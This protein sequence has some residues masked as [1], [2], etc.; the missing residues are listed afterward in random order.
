MRGIF[1]YD[2]RD[3]GIA[4]IAT[5]CRY[6]GLKIS[7]QYV[8]N[9][10][11]LDKNGLSMYGMISTFEKIGLQS[12]ALKGNYLELLDF[13]EEKK[14]PFIALVVD[15]FFLNHYII[16]K[17]IKKGKIFIFDPA[18]GNKIMKQK[19][20]EQI[21]TG[22]I[23]NVEK[24][25]S[26]SK[27]E[28]HKKNLQLYY[29]LVTSNGYKFAIVGIIS[30][31]LSILTLASAYIY[32]YIIDSYIMNTSLNSKEL[33]INTAQSNYIKYIFL[34]FMVI[35]L[36]RTIIS[37]VRGAIFA[38]VEK[39]IDN[40]IKSKFT[41]C[42]ISIPIRYY[43]DRDSGEIINR[44][45]NIVIITDTLVNILLSIV[46]EIVM[47]FS[48][49]II[50]FFTN[51][52]LFSVVAIVML[53]YTIIVLLFKSPLSKLNKQG[54][55]QETNII[56]QLKE[57]IDGLESIKGLCAEN[58]VIKTLQKKIS[59]NTENTYRIDI[60]T[61]FLSSIISCIESIALLFI[62]MWGST[63]VIS[64]AM[65]L[66][67]LIMF[68]S[69]IGFFITP[70]ESLIEYFPILQEAYIAFNRLDDVFEAETE[71]EEYPLNMEDFPEKQDIVLS[72]NNLF[73]HY[74]YEDDILSDVTFHIKSGEKIFLL[75]GSGS[76]KSTLAKLLVRFQDPSSGNIFA[77]NKNIKNINIEIL[78]KNIIYTSQN[79]FIFSGTVVENLMVGL[80][81]VSDEHFQEVLHFCGINDILIKRNWD[82]NS[83]ISEDGRNLSEG[84]KQRISIAR[85]LLR[86]GQIYIFDEATNHM[87]KSLEQKIIKYIYNKL[88]EKTCIFIMHNLD[89]LKE[90][91]RIFILNKGYVTEYGTYD[92]LITDSNNYSEIQS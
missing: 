30:V 74:G 48:S 29:Q 10:A 50:L 65:T 18:I 75:G 23:I 27:I 7:T 67:T 39:N 71:K 4:C 72:V 32:Q 89:Y 35:Y 63:M 8:R 51:R 59:L 1:Q 76:G 53:I 82:L 17:K 16:V 38:K 2:K 14:V 28:T 44:Y 87:D 9:I 61:T 64:N 54:M 6:L 69:Y 57:C 52:Y 81:A 22:Y 25:E 92:E 77:G 46:L 55:E 41:D 85:S 66:G 80:D 26:Y 15:D 90:A 91:D 70:M 45:D 86:Q 19:V 40:G 47:L 37:I 24:E 42:C 13:Y 83:Y 12:N 5:Y 84:E 56:T 73:F 78:R 68:E 20:F 33:Q 11:Y 21:W 88:K 79:T 31:I 3:C 58:S 60:L 49:G 43:N 36:T 34:L 62:L